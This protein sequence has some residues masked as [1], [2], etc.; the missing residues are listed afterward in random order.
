MS[1]KLTEKINSRVVSAPPVDKE[2]KQC[3]F[4][5]ILRT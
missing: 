4:E 3:E 5:K 1:N 2:I